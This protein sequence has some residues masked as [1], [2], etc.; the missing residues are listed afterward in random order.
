MTGHQG[1]SPRQHDVLGLL[2]FA[3]QVLHTGDTLVAAGAVIGGSDPGEE[4]FGADAPGGFGELCRQVHRQWATALDARARE[5]TGQGARLVD[6]AQR[7]GHVAASY[8]DTDAT[9]ASRI[10]GAEP[11]SRLLRAARPDGRSLTVRPDGA[12]T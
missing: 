10:T 6:T 12:V 9:L 7:L 1:D 3:G 4:S 11:E 8:T 2:E 5:A